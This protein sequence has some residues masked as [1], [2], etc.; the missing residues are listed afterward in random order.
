M[1]RGANMG[2]LQGAPRA[3]VLAPSKGSDD[4]RSH[5]MSLA[6]GDNTR[7][8]QRALSV[9]RD[10]PLRGADKRG[11]EAE[12]LVGTGLWWTW[13]CILVVVAHKGVG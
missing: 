7:S 1:A 12:S 11:R 13:R 3:A 5:N 2:R 9:D 4:T 6:L 10:N 8:G